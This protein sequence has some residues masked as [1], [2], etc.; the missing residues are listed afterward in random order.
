M[1]VVI[2]RKLRARQDMGVTAVPLDNGQLTF[3]GVRQIIFDL[4]HILCL[5]NRLNGGRCSVRADG[6]LV[7]HRI[8]NILPRGLCLLKVIRLAVLVGKLWKLDISILIAGHGWIDRFGTALIFIQGKF[9][10]GQRDLML[11]HHLEGNAAAHKAV[12]QRQFDLFRGS[13]GSDHQ[14]SGSVFR[15]TEGFCTHKCIT[16][17][18]TGRS[19]LHQLVGFTQL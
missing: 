6:K 8:R 16:R 18:I 19:G 10:T 13:C 15:N 4:V 12:F 7:G 2:Q 1:L 11:V 3:H 14:I 17:L 5:T 9:R